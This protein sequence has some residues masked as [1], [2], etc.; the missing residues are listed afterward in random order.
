M[1][2]IAD[3]GE[4]KT[5]EKYAIEQIGIPSLVLMER[6]AISVSERIKSRFSAKEIICVVCGIG[7][8]G[9]DGVAVARQLLEDNYRVDIVLLGNRNKFSNEMMIQIGILERMDVPVLDE[10]PDKDYDCFVDAIFGIGLVRDI[11]DAGILKA[12]DTINS[13]DAY[14]YSVDIPTG[15]HTDTGRIMGRAVR[16]DETITFTCVKTGICLYP[17]KEYAG[18]VIKKDIGIHPSCIEMN[19]T[20]HFY[21]EKN[22]GAYLLKR[23]PNGNKGTFGKVAVIAGNNEISGAALLCA[24]AVLKCGAGMVKVLSGEKTLDIVRKTI[25]EAM[26]QTIDNDEHM[27]EYIKTAISWADS[28]VI[29][30]GIGTD[31]QAYLKMRYALM[32]FPL[33]K[34]LIVDADGINLI[35]KYHDLKKLTDKVKKIVY[36]PH[37]MELSRLTGMETGYLKENLDSVMEKVIEENSNAVYVCKDSVTRVYKEGQPVFLNRFGNSGM[38]TAGSGDVLAGIIGALLA[39]EDM[40]VFEGSILGVHLHSLAGDEAAKEFG[41]N[42]L[43]AGDIIKALTGIL[44]S[45][46]DFFHV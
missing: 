15:I 5:I 16:A 29:G 7:N 30:P 13:S 20:R 32:D 44:K 31:H 41:E 46:E 12:I 35:A 2:H 36:T 42:S 38:A 6:A 11:I 28:I 25:P 37:M 1:R 22:D 34:S 21:Y 33:K 4:M 17:G 43:L 27:A 10:I 18:K 26:T 14:I 23:N 3:S 8:N 45:M 24:E 9:A 40:D 39:R 19:K